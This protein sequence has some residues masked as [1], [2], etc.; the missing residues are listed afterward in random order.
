MSDDT[1]TI[2]ALVEQIGGLLNSAKNSG[3]SSPTD[4]AGEPIIGSEGKNDNQVN[5]RAP[6]ITTNLEDIDRAAVQLGQ[7]V[8]PV[9]SWDELNLKPEIRRA[10]VEVGFVKPSVIQETALPLII[11]HKRNLIAQA[12]NGSGKTAC[13]TLGLLSVVDSGNPKTQA[14]VLSPTRELAKQNLDVIGQLGRFCGLTTQLVVPMAEGLADA[15]NAQILSG[16]PGKVLELLRKRVINGKGVCMFVLDEADVMISPEN[17]M[18]VQ[19][20]NIRSLLNSNVQTLLFSATYPESVRRFAH[21]IVPK[22]AKIEVK[23]TDLTLSTIWQVWMQS[24]AE[25]SKFKILS[26]LYA[27]MNVG[28]SI[29]FVNS[30][31]TALDLAK[32]MKDDGHSVSL[33]CGSSKSANGQETV[34]PKQRD[35]VLDEFRSG[36]SKVLIATDVLARG[37]DVPAV[38]LVINYELP[39]NYEGPDRKGVNLETYLHRIGRTGRFGQKGVAVNLVTTEENEKITKIEQFY[40]CHIE[41]LEADID[42]LETRLKEIGEMNKT[43]RANANV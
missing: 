22:A 19:V 5:V 26:D 13:F 30:R 43:L 23:T 29:I 24:S 21:Q 25:I 10:L 35:Q 7:D 36:V 16:T 18:G 11:T 1:S 27:I 6:E 32:K 15:A 9:K 12:K 38:T 37:I 39:I 8:T 4:T 20:S 3:G 33:I 28:Q 17:N 2:S 14:M 34:E 31:N 42:M 41:K 40:N